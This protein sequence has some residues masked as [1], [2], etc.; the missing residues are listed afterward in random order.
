MINSIKQLFMEA[1][2]LLLRAKLSVS[3][4]N[5]LCSQQKN[6]NKEN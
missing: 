1:S 4:F 2:K 6:L 5:S 3:V